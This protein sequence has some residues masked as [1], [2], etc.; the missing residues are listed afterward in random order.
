MQIQI[1]RH[2]RGPY[3]ADGDKNHVFVFQESCEIRCGRCRSYLKQIRH[4]LRQD[5][6]LDEVADA[7]RSDQDKD[8]CLD[9]PAFPAFE[10]T[11]AEARR[12]R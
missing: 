3:D 4:G 5:E 12:T 1:V 11:G 9:P 8:H 10:A 6:D 7:N 2:H